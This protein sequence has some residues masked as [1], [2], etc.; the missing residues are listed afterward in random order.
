LTRV[1][2]MAD[3]KAFGFDRE[4]RQAR[5]EMGSRPAHRSRSYIGVDSDSLLR[6]QPPRCVRSRIAQL[7]CSGRQVHGMVL[8]VLRQQG[9]SR[10][11]RHGSLEIEGRSKVGAE[12]IGVGRPG[13]VVR[14]GPCVDT[15]Y[16]GTIRPDVCQP[17]CRLCR[18]E[19]GEGWSPLR[20]VPCAGTFQ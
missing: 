9:R 13:G 7:L 10:S 3:G 11:P 14:V 2:F 18:L 5:S 16:Q 6:L 8:K 15:R 20:T 12:G 19:C 1:V 17:A 4:L